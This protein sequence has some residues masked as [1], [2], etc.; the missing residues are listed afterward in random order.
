MTTHSTMTT[1]PMNNA[2]PALKPSY[3]ILP[4][5]FVFLLGFALPN[6]DGQTTFTVAADGTGQFTTIT[7][8]LE[9]AANSGEANVTIDVAPGTYRENLT[10][11]SNV[12]V[13]LTSNDPDNPN[14]VANTVI[15]ANCVGTAI[16]VSGDGD[17]AVAEHKIQ[18]FTIEN[19]KDS[20]IQVLIGGDV[21]IR[22]N[23][24]QNNSGL[25]G[26]GIFVAEAGRANIDD[27]LLTENSA[28]NSGGG[29]HAEGSTIINNNRIFG[30]EAMRGGGFAVSGAIVDVTGNEIQG[31]SAVEGGSYLT[32]DNAITT[33]EDNNISNNQAETDGG[34]MIRAE[35]TLLI[36]NTTSNNRSTG[37]GGGVAVMPGS[38][39]GNFTAPGIL[40]THRKKDRRGGPDTA[41]GMA[42]RVPMFH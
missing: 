34:G 41:A 7:A 17:L 27:N 2:L 6:V 4:V 26:G 42:P 21:V 37:S 10:I 5:V 11:P 20:G 22:K 32:D 12:N 3:R 9:A 1:D 19:A 13:C 31:N 8:A 35:E 25:D 15:D 40:S 16:T 24:I 39:S 23:V 33:I 38:F 29:I 36:N 14:T 28:K 30:N 18:G